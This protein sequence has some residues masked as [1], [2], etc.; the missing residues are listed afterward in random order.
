[1]VVAGTLAVADVND[2]VWWNTTGGR[3][4]EHRDADRVTCSLRIYDQAGS[5]TFE[6]ARGSAGYTISAVDPRWAFPVGWGGPVAL[7][8][9]DA[10][11]S[12]GGG[13]VVLDA[14]GDGTAVVFPLKQPVD[15]LLASAD[16]M[17]VKTQAG[18]L[19]VQVPRSKMETLLAR[20]QMC[21]AAG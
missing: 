11:L 21:L 4:T 16:Q 15:G 17:E 9:G 14:V 13:S 2:T 10:W 8:V 3:V 20:M 6:R 7:R 12:N 19:S 1:M 18:S 5:L